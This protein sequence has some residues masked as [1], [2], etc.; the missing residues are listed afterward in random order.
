MTLNINKKTGD[1][2]T[3][4]E[5]NQIVS[6]INTK[7][8]SQPG[9]EL[10]TNDFTDVDKNLLYGLYREINSAITNIVKKGERQIGFFDNN[11]KQLPLY[12]AFFEVA[13]PPRTAG[14]E[15][16]VM[17]LNEPSEFI[18]PLGV[19]LKKPAT[20]SYNN[21]SVGEV[22]IEDFSTKLTLCCDKDAPEGIVV[23]RLQYV[24]F[25]GKRLSFQ[26]SSSDNSPFTFSNVKIA[27]LK[28]NKKWVCSYT[29]DD[30]PAEAFSRVF[31]RINKKWMDNNPKY[32]VN[33]PRT[34]GYYNSNFLVSTDGAGNDVRWSFL[35]AIF[36]TAGNSYNPD[37]L[38]KDDSTTSNYTTW[39][40]VNYMKHF[41]NTIAFH[42]INNLKFN[43]SDPEQIAQGFVDDYNRAFE[44]TGLRMKI[45][46]RPDG[47][48]NYVTAAQASPLVDFLR[49]AGS[50]RIYPK[51]LTTSLVKQELQ[52]IT[53]GS[54]Y[55]E[56]LAE[57]A[58]V[59]A[60][61]NP[62]WA[63]ITTHTPDA[64]T[65][66]F[67]ETMYTLYGKGGN[68]SV[69]FAG[70]EEVFEYLQLKVLSHVKAT[71]D[72]NKKIV[73]L[74][75][76]DFENFH[77]KEVSIIANTNIPADKII[78]TT[79]DNSIKNITFSAS[80]TTALV[81]IN[82]NEKAEELTE[83]FV[84]RYEQSATTEDKEDALYFSNK[85]NPITRQPYI[86][87]INA[88]TD[89]APSL[90]VTAITITGGNNIEVGKSGN[91]SIS[92]TP[93]NTTQQGVTWSSSDT[94]KATVTTAGV[95]TA[96]AAGNVTITARSTYNTT[97]SNSISMTVSEGSTQPPVPQQQFKAVLAWTEGFS[98]TYPVV[99]SQT[100][101]Y[102]RSGYLTSKD[103]EIIKDTQGTPRGKLILK[104]ALLPDSAN[105]SDISVSVGSN[106]VLE[107]DLGVYPDMYI[108]QNAGVYSAT[109]GAQVLRRFTD[110]PQGTYKLRLLI[111]MKPATVN[112]I[113]NQY[114]IVQ[115][116]KSY[117]PED[118]PYGNNNTTFFEIENVAVSETG[119][120]DIYIGNNISYA[121]SGFNL[122]E[123]IKI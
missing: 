92:Y 121:R 68:D 115:G 110:L 52:G 69:W 116:V 84:T 98:E 55:A 48:N 8:D 19:S 108:N 91:L 72:D 37:G 14:T 65:I 95:V 73:D 105:L 85:L 60:S 70:I 54:S 12:E 34:T 64:D 113:S 4:T 57:F 17:I 13:N 23:I 45:L 6:E 24:R 122:L 28:Y 25:P 30:S 1:T 20:E 89:P 59:A 53:A 100:L 42:N 31:S 43:E 83:M 7:L 97:I 114:F 22:Y 36:A 111:S 38:M 94:T 58:T 16:V 93:V 81:N 9:K 104:K 29:I 112:N 5:I 88:V 119:I 82:Y 79:E 106:P 102:F 49:T 21:Y 76:P 80:G 63:G 32:H 77:F 71:G 120:L 2:L 51:Q 101:N 11:N 35:Q 40:D 99:D 3:A 44:K 117:L 118:Y 78:V 66:T 10:S 109:V 47:N 27:P 46:A 90:P 39:K 15:A 86:N 87:R 62:Y 123:F 74:F 56:K 61:D 26:I 107:G 75:L 18:Y 50:Q 67:L 103:Q 33:S 96:I 41:G